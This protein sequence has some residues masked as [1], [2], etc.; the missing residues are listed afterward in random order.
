MTEMVPDE[1]L[2]VYDRNMKKF[3]S[4][5]RVAVLTEA[6]FSFVPEIL[7]IFE[8]QSIKFLEIFSGRVID[9]P[10]IKS[11]IEKMQQVSIWILMETARQRGV[12]KEVAVAQV[13]TKFR[14]RKIEVRRVD[15][16]M[17]EL[18]SHMALEFKAPDAKEEEEKGS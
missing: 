16:A 13:A 6:R 1:V 12:V 8:E 7:D 10:P 9:V 18:L 14:I 5:L 3:I 4:V 2:Q 17:S 11:L 15:E